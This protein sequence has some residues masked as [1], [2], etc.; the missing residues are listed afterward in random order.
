MNL[1]TRSPTPKTR[2]DSLG[3]R[4]RHPDMCFAVGSASHWTYPTSFYRSRG[5]PNPFDDTA[6]ACECS[7]GLFKVLFIVLSV[8][9]IEGEQ[10]VKEDTTLSITSKTVCIWRLNP[11][12]KNRGC[13][14]Q[15]NPMQFP[16]TDCCRFRK[17]PTQRQDSNKLKSSLPEIL[18]G[19]PE[20]EW[21]IRSVNSFSM[22]ANAN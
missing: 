13:D 21:V 8:S 4:L 22:I 15:C 10:Q 1:K 7:R 16:L 5:G 17:L 3:F 19:T 20:T 2:Y 18:W 12:T 6:V 9:L 11:I 14:I